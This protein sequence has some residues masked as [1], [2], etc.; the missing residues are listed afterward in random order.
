M[1]IVYILG[2]GSRYNDDEIRYSLRSL[3]N[4]P[5]DNVYVIGEKPD[6][7]S[8]NVIHIPAEDPFDVKQKNAFHKLTIACNTKEISDDFIL[9]NDDFF[10]LKP[11]DDVPHY[12]KRS[13]EDSIKYHI[14]EK[15]DY[16]EAM[17][18]TFNLLKKKGKDFSHHSPFVYNKKRLL[19][20]LKKEYGGTVH[21]RTLYANKSKIEG[22]QRKD[23][24]V[25]DKKDFEEM[26]NG[27]IISTDDLSFGSNRFQNIIK[28]L[29]PK[30][31]KYEK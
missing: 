30:K 6:F 12:Y 24:K 22:I 3:I 18:H 4:L 7:F 21:L 2:T 9:M 15:G 31:C 14:S 1:D 8:D 16:Y 13:L 5:H 26:K 29:F 20:L 28:S 17:V 19:T 25:R 10:I 23:V 11:V 27:D